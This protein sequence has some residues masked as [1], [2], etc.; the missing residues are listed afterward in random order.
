MGAKRKAIKQDLIDQLDR[1]GVY[2]AHYLDLIDDY[3]AMWDVKA[4]LIADIKA[5]GVSVEYA[6][7]WGHKK[8]DSVAE[9]T[10]TNAQMLKILNELG[11]RATD[12]EVVDT[13]DEEL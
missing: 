8:N 4:M 13:D 1:S 5:R 3:M 9:L 6:N 2:G 12:F 11:L 7:Q 10:R